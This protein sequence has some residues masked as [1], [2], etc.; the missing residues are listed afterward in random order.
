MAEHWGTVDPTLNRDLDDIAATYAGGRT[1]VAFDGDRV[2][3][4]GTVVRHAD[5]G[6]SAEIVRMS[7]APEYRRTGLGRR[8]VSE[9][10]DVARRWGVS[11]IVL[12][13]T[14]H[15]TEVVTVLRAMWFHADPL[16]ER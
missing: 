8:L 5:G 1:L 15:W 6:G 10:V 4:T 7:V 9:L 2:V 16:R 14:A 11:R 13:T 3:G 12:E